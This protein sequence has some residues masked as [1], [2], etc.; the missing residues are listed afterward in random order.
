M[1]SAGQ[2][3]W[4]APLHQVPASGSAL[5]PCLD[6]SMLYLAR[7]LASSR[8][9]PCQGPRP[10]LPSTKSPRGPASGSSQRPLT[11]SYMAFPIMRHQSC[12]SGLVAPLARLLLVRCP[13]AALAGPALRGPSGCGRSQER[14][15][16]DVARPVLLQAPTATRWD[17]QPAGAAR[18]AA[19][20]PRPA[21]VAGRRGRRPL[22]Q[23]RRR[24]H[25]H[26]LLLHRHRPECRQ[27]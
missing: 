2:S 8:S 9:I 15:L 16:V 26:H 25:H 7:L 27:Q 24:P 23:Q 6:T 21:A 12:S 20:R 3:G 10:R 13:A 5:W 17:S 22:R 19:P 14:L 1:P 18:R 11:T 4:W